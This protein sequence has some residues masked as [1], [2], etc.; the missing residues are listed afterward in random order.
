MKSATLKISPGKIQ[1]TQLDGVHRFLGIPYAEPP[2][3]AHRFLPPV[4]RTP[5]DGVLDTSRYGAI[6]P[7]TGGMQW[8]LPDE[9]EDCL[10]LNVWTPDPASKG[11]PVMV[12][13][14]GGG[15]TTGSGAAEL[16][17][18]TN[19]AKSGV[20]LVTSNRRL[21]AEGYLYLPE[22]F[23]D[24]VGPGNLGIMDLIEVLRWVQENIE[25]F[26]GDPSNVTL[27]GESGGGAAT[28]A[29]VATPQSKGLVHR[30]IPQSGGHAAQRPEAATAITAHVMKQLGI[31]RG[32][33]NTLRQVPWPTF[34]EL[35]SELEQLELGWPQV[36]LPVI[37]EAMPN[38]PVDAIDA[39][40]G[41]EI[42]YL[43]GTCRDEINLFSALMPGGMEGSV[44][45]RRARFVVEKSGA[46]WNQLEAV[47]RQSRPDLDAE[48]AAKAIMGDMWFRAPSIRIADSHAQHGSAKT[49]MYLF[50][51]ESQ[52]LGAAH[53][54]D[55]MVFG[56]GL[57]FGP[58]GG[59]AS[60]DQTAEFMR[61][62]WVNFATSGDPGV[63]TFD[64]PVYDLAKRSTVALNETPA[65]LQDP[66]QQ[67]RALLD[68]VLS[69]SW[70]TLGL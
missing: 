35:Y 3:G 38:H 39:G 30:V 8:G 54:M 62:A 21:G 28:Q 46:D 53:G 6:C 43:I 14:H 15:Q 16:Y 9:G 50:T 23:G 48:D 36:Y 10:N 61:K 31:K 42:D 59:F 68:T 5:W 51:W 17:D 25:Q 57:P 58:L 56:N 60:Y 19:F 7:Q 64:W 18:G 37:S 55:L 70:E 4:R 41:S 32:D 47:Y 34:V 63:G 12:W 40:L 66:Y 65:I 49:W 13:A 45:D 52:I 20:V 29:V 33:I 22:F 1:G 69:S 2:F 24:G 11:L 26:G 44:F 67:Q 27:F